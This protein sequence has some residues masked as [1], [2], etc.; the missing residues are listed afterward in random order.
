MQGER[1]PASRGRCAGRPLPVED[2]VNKLV[3]KDLR[4]QT[5]QECMNLISGGL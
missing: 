1:V 4:V 3:P 2:I 5:E